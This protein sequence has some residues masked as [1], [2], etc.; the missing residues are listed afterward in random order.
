MGEE[1]A[2]CRDGAVKRAWYEA[3][4]RL[5]NQIDRNYESE[6]DF[7]LRELQ[8]GKGGVTAAPD[9]DTRSYLLSIL[10]TER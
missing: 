9:T 2:S 8:S 1:A 5:R 4:Q 10:Q 3:E 6:M 7:S